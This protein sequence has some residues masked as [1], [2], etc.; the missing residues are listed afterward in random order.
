MFC[1]FM[2]FIVVSTNHIM[3]EFRDEKLVACVYEAGIFVSKS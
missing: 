2:P 3:L 1:F